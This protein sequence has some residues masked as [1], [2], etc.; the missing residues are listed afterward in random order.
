MSTT[1]NG[2][3][4]TKVITGK[5]RLSYAH[6]FKPWAGETGQE[7]KYS[8]CI[9]IPKSDKVTIGKIKAAIEAAK[10]AGISKWGG[11]IPPNLKNPLRD[12]D[13]ERPDDPAFKNSYFLNAS[14]KMKPG[15]IDRDKQEILD[16]TEVYS[17]CYCRFSINFFPF[18]T[19]GNKGIGCGLN[20]VQKVADGEFLGGR[21][22]AEDEFDEWTEDDL[23]EPDFL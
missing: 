16:S 15:I 3:S 4:T 9:I 12:G 21:A 23:E 11:K 6:L 1:K 20:N 2:A 13:I 22:R 19:A 7:E 17:G 8:A 10:Q 18:N 5:C 14:S